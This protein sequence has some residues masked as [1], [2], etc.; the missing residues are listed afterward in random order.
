MASTNASTLFGGAGLGAT[1]QSA[2]IF[3]NTSK[4][5]ALTGGTSFAKQPQVPQQPTPSSVF[6]QNQTQVN[7]A[8]QSGQTTQP[9]FFNSLLE[10]GKKRPISAIGQNGNYE[11]LPSLQLGLDDI[12]RK[13]RELGA[14]GSK[15]FQQ[16]VP[17]SKAHYLLAASGVS[18]GH[19]LRDL[20]ALDPQ[21]SVATTQKEQ[22]LFDPDNQ[23]FLRSIQQRGRQ[24]MITESLAR[25]HRDFDLFLEEKVDMDWEEQR[26]K[27]FQHF[28]LA[29]KED[30]AGDAKAGFGRSVRRPKQLG[31]TSTNGPA[32]TSRRS[33]FGR[34]ALEKS[35][36]GTPGTGT[37]SIRLFEDPMDRNDGVGHSDLR[38]LREKMGY[39]ADKVRQLNSARLH[40]RT[41]P[42][43]HE[44]SDVEGHV[45]GDVPRQM[46][47]A[48]RALISIVGESPNVTNTSDPA[49]LA[50][51]QFSEDYLDEVP[52]SR[53]AV[54]LRKRIVEGSR[55][56]L[57]KLFY[58]EIEN[59]IA[60]NP[61]E[62]QLGGIPTVTNKIRAYIRL[63]AARKDLAPDGTEL[64]MV[65]QDYCWILIFYLLRCGF[66]TEAAE[67]VSQDPGF[68]SLD[69][70]FVTYMTT[71]AQNRR[72][73]RDL[74]QKINGEYQQRSRNAPDNTVDPY[75]MACYKII[76]RCELSR[77]R[78]EGVN[79][80]VE[81]WMWLQFSLAREDDRAEE[82]AG[83]V[84][85]LE[86]I[87]TDITEIGQRVF[88]KGQEGPGG[89]GTFFLLQ[90]LGG[91]FEQA[92]SYLGS[93]APIT[94]VHFAIALA[95]YGLLRVSDFYTSGEEILSFTVKQYPQINFGYLIT[96]Y[97]REFRTGYVE[98]A[99]DY[100]TLLCLNADLPGSLGRS[101]ASVCH[102]AL[103]EF[104]LETRDF[105]KLLG[106][107]RSDGSRIKGLI[108]QRMSLIKLVDQDE[109]LKT[110][111]VQAAA[112]ADDK[113]LI[114]DAVLLY[115][116]AEDYDRV[117]DII[118]RALSDA[119]AVELGG[120]ALKLQPLRPRA[121]LHE[122]APETPLEPGSSLS[123]TT[124]DDP[125]ILAKN[126][127]GLYNANAMYYQ[128]IRQVNRDACGLLLRMMEAKVEVEAA[129]WTPALDAIND[130]NILPLRA[131]GSVPYIRSAAQTFSSFPPIISHNVGHVI[132][133]SITCIGHERER[134]SSGA[135]ENEIRQG[136]ADE[137]LV[138]AKDLMI[139]SG[140]VKYKL[141]PKVYETLARAGAQIGAY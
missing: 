138:M 127:I 111:T 44:F 129:K 35:V 31:P 98:A 67:Y 120:P 16:H 132:M 27:I 126:M 48:Y 45:G 3:G 28:G 101:Q 96:Q 18:P 83:D 139:F 103:R 86:D 99:I 74:Q 72:L 17:H 6:G 53:R 5:P 33:V 94:A 38:F 22:D 20:K 55:S 100:F 137:L 95:Y 124:V 106:D 66:V 4:S 93:Y 68:R 75:R 97:T 141:P 105:A 79:Q 130:L 76:G 29:Q 57:E 65:G 115:H 15:E 50:E 7:A 117:I 108:E 112:I 118:N 134:L 21:A 109:F 19:A 46:Y 121:N 92:V 77:R 78:L 102:E 37:A 70:K 133:W 122:H 1:A 73:P 40:T 104:I 39:Y 49:A 91:M 25:T 87:Q 54:S 13:A 43:L 34:S 52:N 32:S 59:V 110:I 2:S 123:L 89:Y 128:R 24:V 114:T 61:R 51:R 82:V 135:Y 56:F 85:G 64:Q 8:Q 81:D 11:D 9:A 26:L 119:V 12:R 36:I 23:K 60:K 30:G 113:G 80:S 41:F 116:L 47:D 136:L 140:M 88:G 107:I 71:Y 14:G 84:F 42:V 125:V 90:I 10:R 62:A 131:R 69:H 58:D 63:R